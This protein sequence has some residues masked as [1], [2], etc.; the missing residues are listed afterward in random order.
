MGDYK[1]GATILPATLTLNLPLTVTLTAGSSPRFLDFAGNG[2]GFYQVALSN[3]PYSAQVTGRL[4]CSTGKVTNGKL[5]GSYN[6]GIPTAFQ[7]TIDGTL[8]RAT[9]SFS[10]TWTASETNPTYG[11][12]GTWQATP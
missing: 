11:G 12:N 2:S 4:D 7:G 6:T 1:T 3:V 5:T 8:D 10:G 9:N